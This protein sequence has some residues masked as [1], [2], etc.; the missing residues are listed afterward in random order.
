MTA[1]E[2]RPGASRG[3][4][5]RLAALPLGWWGA[6][7]GLQVALLTLP[8]RGFIY[9]QEPFRFLGI[10]APMRA[11]DYDNHVIL[12][13]ELD[14][15][16]DPPI[17][18]FLFQAM[19]RVV[20]GVLPGHSLDAAALI[21]TLS[22]VAAG[23]IVCFELVRLP[24]GGRHLTDPAAA[25]VTSLVLLVSLGPVSLN[26]WESPTFLV[27]KPF[28]L[29]LVIVV[30]R[31]F[32]QAAAGGRLS[33]ALRWG[34]AALV[35]AST[36]AK[37]S[38]TIVLVPAAV[39][40][41]LV[42]ARP[43][44]RRAGW[45]AVWQERLRHQAKAWFW[46]IAVP[47]GLVSAWSFWVLR[48]GL[49][50]DPEDPLRSPQAASLKFAPFDVV[51]N[52][53]PGPVIGGFLLFLFIALV[54]AGL[55]WWLRQDPAVG[56][57]AWC[58]LF[59]QAL[60]LFFVETAETVQYDGNLGWPAQTVMFLL[61]VLLARDI[62]VLFAS[63]DPKLRRARVAI[64]VVLFHLCLLLGAAQGLARVACHHGI[65]ISGC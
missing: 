14:R 58:F 8:V 57:L 46:W 52:L 27:L 55:W 43:L 20:Q 18:H 24:V 29:G 39:V 30:P 25:A 53:D 12:A 11:W 13:G 1:V 47:G 3:S 19:V 54:T 10:D 7:A 62:A 22:M 45:R 34:T 48:Y 5:A 64:P 35:V 42:Q 60:V 33:G 65:G 6:V 36:L 59:A 37:G 41:L 49:E 26:A 31:L 38:L 61:V 56:L 15:P 4:R 9:F 51:T 44:A 40:W 63:P 21:V 32:E 2:D 50:L 17:P 16:W 23:A 28:A